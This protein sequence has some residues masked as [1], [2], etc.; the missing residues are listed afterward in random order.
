V[1]RWVPAVARSP[2]GAAVLSR[3]AGAGVAV[4]GTR[5][6]SPISPRAW[7]SIA[8]RLRSGRVDVVH[9]HKF[10]AN[11]AAAVLGA[12][13][14]IPVVAH[15]HGPR[16]TPSRTRAVADRR[17]IARRA[18]LVLSVSSRSNACR[19]GRCAICPWVSPLPTPHRR[20]ARRRASS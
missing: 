3:L 11:V 1:T 5:R 6:R 14:G 7:A 12:A 10:G 4:F 17:L 20:P 8:D 13:A 16:A 19:R 2:D 15:E 18:S 9:S